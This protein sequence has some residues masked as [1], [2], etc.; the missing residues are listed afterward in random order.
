M[1]YRADTDLRCSLRPDRSSAIIFVKMEFP[2]EDYRS[3][4]GI[5]RLGR[6]SFVGLYQ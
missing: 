6:N 2:L 5:A 4:T 3:E 1:F